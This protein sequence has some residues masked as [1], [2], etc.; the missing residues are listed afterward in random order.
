M[1]TFRSIKLLWGILSRNFAAY[2]SHRDFIE[3]IVR[4]NLTQSDKGYKRLLISPTARPVLSLS[5]Q[6]RAR[7]Q[8]EKGPRHRAP[9]QPHRAPSEAPP[10]R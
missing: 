8:G 3:H 1:Q 5:K 4:I 9:R 10:A 2:P 7:W 6:H